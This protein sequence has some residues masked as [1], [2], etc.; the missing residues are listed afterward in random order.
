VGLVGTVYR[1]CPNLV[2]ATT[3]IL[4]AEDDP[5]ICDLLINLLEVEFAA[6]VR[7]ERMGSPALQV[8]KRLA[9]TLRS[10]T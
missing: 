2:K 6:T 1:S 7:C 4:V 10:S 8:L 3:A 9:L 5:G